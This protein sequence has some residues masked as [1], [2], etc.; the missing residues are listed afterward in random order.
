[1]RTHKWVIADVNKRSRSGGVEHRADRHRD[2]VLE[3]VLSGCEEATAV[4]KTVEGAE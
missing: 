3:R 1:M 2:G 4:F